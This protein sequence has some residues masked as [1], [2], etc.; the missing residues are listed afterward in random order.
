[1]YIL[2]RYIVFYAVRI[3]AYTLSTRL[4][5]HN[6]YYKIVECLTRRMSPVAITHHFQIKHNKAKQ[7]CLNTLIL[8]CW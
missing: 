7:T 6:I 2:L 4:H 1:M 3:P 8:L 5:V